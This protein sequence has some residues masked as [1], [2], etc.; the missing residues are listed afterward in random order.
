M[1]LSL[2]SGEIL[3]SRYLIKRII[4]QGGMGSIYLAE[5]NAF[6]RE[7]MRFKRGRAR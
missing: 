5:D 1:P 7:A 4:G 3:R 6:E 2:K